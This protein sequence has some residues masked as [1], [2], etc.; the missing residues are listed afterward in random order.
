VPLMIAAQPSPHPG[1]KTPPIA[2]LATMV[3]VALGALLGT[4]FFFTGALLFLPLILAGAV[5]LAIWSHR[6]RNRP[7]GEGQDESPP[8]ESE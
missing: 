8:R 4:A 2:V 5:V 6:R 1:R 3:L 7:S